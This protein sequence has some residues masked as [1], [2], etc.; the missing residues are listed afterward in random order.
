MFESSNEHP[1]TMSSVYKSESDGPKI[2]IEEDHDKYGKKHADYSEKGKVVQM[3]RTK[4][5]KEKDSR[6]HEHSNA[7]KLKDIIGHD[8][9]SKDE[10]ALKEKT[11]IEFFERGNRTK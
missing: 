4:F 10:K 7:A 11:Q 3:E 9:K 6:G 8:K 5:N 1:V 2:A